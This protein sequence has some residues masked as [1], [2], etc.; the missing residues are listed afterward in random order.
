[1]ATP[2]I[3]NQGSRVMFVNEQVER[4][5]PRSTKPTFGA[6][7][8]KVADVALSGVEVG[9]TVMGGPLVGAA[10]RGVRVGAQA[11]TGGAIGGGPLSPAGGGLAAGAV[12]G[13][14][15]EEQGTLDEVRAMQEQA[16]DFNLQY[17]ALQEEVQQ[18]N[19]RFSTVSNVLKARHD[20]AKA[21]VQNI[22]S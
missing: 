7:M 5:A 15:G 4:K 9:A 13:S 6:T 19:R 1:M 14:G 11:A 2:K 3:V 16:Q 18:E 17:L 22:H 10:V 8:G 21:A 20:T 12:G